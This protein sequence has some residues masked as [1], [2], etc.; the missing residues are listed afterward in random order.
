MA[1]LKKRTREVLE[2]L[3]SQEAQSK[4]KLEN[5]SNLKKSSSNIQ[6]TKK[7]SN[8][9]SIYQIKLEKIINR[10]NELER[11][12]KHGDNYFTHYW[13]YSNHCKEF[14]EALKEFEEFENTFVPQQLK[15]RIQDTKIKVQAH[16]NR[17][18]PPSKNKSKDPDDFIGL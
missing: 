9:I 16:L 11:K 13:D 18:L 2:R 6:T 5:L 17:K 4:P 10:L 7:E 3:K 15:N 12:M 1:E 8:S 14:I